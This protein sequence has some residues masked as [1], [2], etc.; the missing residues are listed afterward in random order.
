MVSSTL[1]AFF[2]PI[3][4]AINGFFL[5]LSL[6]PSLNFESFTVGLIG[7]LSAAVFINIIFVL[8]FVFY[9]QNKDKLFIKWREKRKIQTN[10]LLILS[11]MISIT[12]FRL[13][14]SKLFE[15]EQFK[16][17]VKNPVKFLRPI[18]VFTWIKFI[19][20]NMPFVYMMY[21]IF[22]SVSWAHVAYTTSLEGFAINF[23]TFILMIWETIKRNDLLEKG[24]KYAK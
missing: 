9:V 22:S 14:Y 4:M 2:G 20:F 19:C 8:F 16:P 21:R 18:L 15:N 17:N 23:F 5:Y 10:L 11:G 6:N 13:I 24:S 1:I 12:L 7:T 3:E